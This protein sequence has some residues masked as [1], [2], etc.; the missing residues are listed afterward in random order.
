M[1]ADRRSQ[2][3]PKLADSL[4]GATR[5]EELQLHAYH[6]FPEQQRLLKTQSLFDLNGK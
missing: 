2:T 6:A 1:D 4:G 5:R 3:T